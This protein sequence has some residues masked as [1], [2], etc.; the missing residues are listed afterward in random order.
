M[1]HALIHSNII[2]KTLHRR[3]FVWLKCDFKLK[4]IMYITDCDYKYE[5]N[6]IHKYIYLNKTF[7]WCLYVLRLH[8]FH[9][10]FDGFSSYFM[11]FFSSSQLHCKT[12]KWKWF[13]HWAKSCSVIYIA[14]SQAFNYCQLLI[15]WTVRFGPNSK[16]LAIHTF[17]SED[18]IIV[19][20]LPESTM[21]IVKHLK[22]LYKFGYKLHHT[23]WYQRI[24][25]KNS[26]CRNW[27]KITNAWLSNS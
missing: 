11:N 25:W 23:R 10:I 13:S 6:T 26:E 17:N 20:K 7:V 3:R 8:N 21:D 19:G 1:L 15:N 18:L 9:W 16:L 27:R 2:C 12:F 22:L 5:W 14:I 24:P 4:A